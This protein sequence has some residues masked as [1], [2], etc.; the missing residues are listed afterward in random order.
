[1]GS[2][3]PKQH[4]LPSIDI[5]GTDCDD[6][7]AAVNP[8]VDADTDGFNICDDCNDAD[9]TIQPASEDEWFDGIDSDCAGNSDYDVDGDGYDSQEYRYVLQLYLHNQWIVKSTAKPG[10]LLVQT[11]TMMMILFIR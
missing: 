4:L 10:P 1:M 8:S 11:A 6:T 9:D 7:D 5:Y 2:S 3:I